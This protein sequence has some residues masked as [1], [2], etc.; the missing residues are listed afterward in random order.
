[1]CC[2]VLICQLPKFFVPFRLYHQLTLKL[3]TFVK[4]PSLQEGEQLLELYSKFIMFIENKWVTEELVV[5]D[6]IQVSFIPCFYL[7]DLFIFQ[8]K[9]TFIGRDIGICRSAIHWLE[10]SCDVFREDGS[11]SEGLRRC[12]DALQ[13]SGRP[14][15]SREII[16][17]NCN[18]GTPCIAWG[19][20]SSLI[21]VLYWL[22]ILSIALFRKLL[23]MLKK[24]WIRRMVLVPYMGGF[25]CWQ[26]TIT[27]NRESTQSI[28]ALLS[29]IWVA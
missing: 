4:H 3:M 11:E 17:Y 24:N 14:N 15:P 19:V 2:F 10:G 13:S 20:A 29:D 27:V 5:A 21:F 22:M 18:K 1:M 12:S 7:S 9:P 16:W 8:N 25:T 28:I 26:V 6:R 23:T